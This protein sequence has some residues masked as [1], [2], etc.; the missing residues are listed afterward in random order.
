MLGSAEKLACHGT[1]SKVGAAAAG[2]NVT[3]PTQWNLDRVTLEA[4]LCVR[5]LVAPEHW[6][7]VVGDTCARGWDALVRST[8]AQ[9]SP[10]IF[11]QVAAFVTSLPST[12]PRAGMSTGRFFPLFST[13]GIQIVL[14][15]LPPSS[16]PTAVLFNFQTLNQ[17]QGTLS[18]NLGWQNQRFKHL[19]PPSETM[20]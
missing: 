17:Q 13:I 6:C 20:L 9:S 5:G 4:P 1:A 18:F 3:F 11:S 16:P 7:G 10:G 12:G 8:M 2:I 15:L 14:L 19:S